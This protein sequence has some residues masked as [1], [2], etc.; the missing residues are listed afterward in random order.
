M[1]DDGSKL[2][3]VAVLADE[4]ARV[5]LQVPVATLDR[6]LPLLAS[7]NGMVK[8]SIAFSRERSWVVADIQFSADLEL[9]CQRCLGRLPLTLAG[10]SQVALVESQAAVDSVPPEWETTLA[11]DGRMRLREL[12]E[13]EV[14]LA[15]P[16]VARHAEGQCGDEPLSATPVQAAAPTQRP[17]AGLGNLL[18]PDRPKK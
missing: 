17:F 3:N 12:M 6:L 9:S 2:N 10:R 4:A 15:L 8:G 14:L 1:P 11:P 18:K 16:P 7:A 13:E 5:E